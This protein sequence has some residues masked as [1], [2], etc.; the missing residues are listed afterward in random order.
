MTFTY[1]S[2]L[3]LRSATGVLFARVPIDA[4]AFGNVYIDTYVTHLH[5]ASSL[6]GLRDCNRSCRR[7][8]L[9]ELA[10]FIRAKSAQSG[11][12]ILVMGDFN[13]GGPNP[14][15]DQCAGNHGYN[16]IMQELRSPR[17]LW[18][19]AHPNEQGAT[20]EGQRIDFMFVLTDPYF[21]NTRYELTIGDLRDV[22]LVKWRIPEHLALYPGRQVSDHYGID[23]I[24]HVQYGA[25]LG[26]IT[27]GRA[28]TIKQVST[29]RYVDAHEDAPL[30]DFRLVLRNAQ[31]NDTQKWR[32][33]SLGNNTFTI[34]QVSSGKFIYAYPYDRYERDYGLVLRDPLP[35]DS[36]R[37]VLE[38]IVIPPEREL[39][40]L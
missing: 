9:M 4:G 13:I 8:E 22:R 28:Y 15:S 6:L 26:G 36:Q 32:L 25:P 29:D 2:L 18:L 20:H 40:R 19:E 30:H 27:D 38:A 1:S 7:S 34:Q 33:K 39:P 17:D 12:P 37:W 23:A 10:G 31:S 5:S 3:A 21:T 14:T 35:E 24:L 16:D 11:N